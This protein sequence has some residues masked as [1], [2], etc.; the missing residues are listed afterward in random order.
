MF[1]GSVHTSRAFTQGFTPPS[2]RIPDL[3][4]VIL[5]QKLFTKDIRLKSISSFNFKRWVGTTSDVDKTCRFSGVILA[6]VI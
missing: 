2:I 5:L 4:G 3:D 1:P 6:K